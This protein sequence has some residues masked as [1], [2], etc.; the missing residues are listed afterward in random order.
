MELNKALKINPGLLKGVAKPQVP[1][2][3][4]STTVAGGTPTTA[5]G[6][7]V[8]TAGGA[9]PTTTVAGP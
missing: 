2:G 7:T 3:G 5:A 6:G 8:T 9:A 1:G 4:T